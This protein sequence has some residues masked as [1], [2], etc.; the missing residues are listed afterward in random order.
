MACVQVTKRNIHLSHQ[1]T[2]RIRSEP[3]MGLFSC[4]SEKEINRRILT[5]DKKIDS[6]TCSIRNL[7]SGKLGY[8]VATRFG[9]C[10]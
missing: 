10:P 9:Y 6:I 1:I 8:K 5:G 4:F 3:Y 2:A 7:Q